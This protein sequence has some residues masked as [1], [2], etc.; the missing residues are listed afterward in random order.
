METLKFSYN[1]N[2]KLN[3]ESFTTLRLQN[4]KYFPGSRFQIVL[5][6]GQ[7]ELS[8]GIAEV[9]EV[10]RVIPMQ[11]TNL[12]CR[13]DTGYSKEETLRM[14]ANMYKNVP[15]FNVATSAMHLVLLRKIKTETPVNR[16]PISKQEPQKFNGMK[17][18]C[19][20]CDK[21]WTHLEVQCQRCDCCNWPENED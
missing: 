2:N 15:G 12:T 1:W 13:Q 17:E 18:I 7:S 8:L 11:L 16:S 20:N 19:P 6:Q 14:M 5:Q 3:C 4:K 21:P 9:E 10:Y